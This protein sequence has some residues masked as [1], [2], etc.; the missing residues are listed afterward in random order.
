M[1]SYL[2]TAINNFFSVSRAPLCLKALRA[3]A[4]GACGILLPLGS[5]RAEAQAPRATLPQALSPAD[6]APA[7]EKLSATPA[8]SSAA[9][10]S[11]TGTPSVTPAEIDSSFQIGDTTGLSGN[12]LFGATIDGLERIFVLDFNAKRIRRVIEGPGNSS[13]PS[14]SPDGRYFAFVSDR[15]GNNEIYAAEW[16]GRSPVRLTTNPGNDENPSWSKDGL[17]IAYSAELGKAGGDATIMILNVPGAPAK[18]ASATPLAKYSGRQTVP[19][20]SPDGKMVSYSTNRFWPGWDV[21]TSNLSTR[22]EKCLLS[23]A[24]T[25][26]RQDYSPDGKSIAFSYGAF[27]DVDLGILEIDS[28]KRT[29]LTSMPGREY[30]ATWSPDGKLVAFTAEDGRKEIY[31]VYAIA[32]GDKK[33]RQLVSSPHSLRFLSWTDARTLELEAER[34]RGE[35]Q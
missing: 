22:Q 1:S 27:D 11:A 13:Y 26:C 10:S 25:F 28:G 14:W 12:L 6:S 24:Q 4:L 16:D 29:Q 35:N 30:D 9:H 15:D 3:W 32:P 34:Q 33:P 7:S 5:F 18:G 21:C 31:N 20:V 19:K 8:A 2:R 23:G 17:K